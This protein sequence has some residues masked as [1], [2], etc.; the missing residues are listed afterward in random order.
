M[1]LPFLG[2]NK[3]DL[4]KKNIHALKLAAKA[5]ENRQKRPQKE[6]IHFQVHACC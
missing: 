1:T 5:P 6:T 2:A 3:K 4:G